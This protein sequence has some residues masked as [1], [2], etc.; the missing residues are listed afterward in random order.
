MGSAASRLAERLLAR[1]WDVGGTTRDGRTGT[2]PFENKDLV[3]ERLRSATHILSSVP[4]DGT[5]DPVLASYGD[6]I[7]VAP[8]TWVGYLSS[9][10]VYGDTGG[11]WVDEGA[12]VQGRRADRNAA[13]A[14]WCTLR[15]PFYHFPLPGL[16]GPRPPMLNPLHPA[17]PHP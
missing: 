13:D 5:F 1:G 7:A 15:G 2:I 17:P 11:A 14:A 6:A 10:G 16:S 9:A 8:A 12:P 3:L 4:P